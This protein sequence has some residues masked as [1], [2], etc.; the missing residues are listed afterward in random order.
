MRLAIPRV[1]LGGLLLT[2]AW[3][4]TPAPAQAKGPLIV[5]FPF[6]AR[7]VPLRPAALATLEEV[8]TT[9]VAV[10]G[11]P[12]VPRDRTLAQLKGRRGADRLCHNAVCQLAVARALG[13]QHAIVSKLRRLGRRCVLMLTLL[14]VASATT[15]RAAE[16]SGPCD[17]ESV[18]ASV[19]GALAKLCVRPKP[20]VVAPR[21]KLLPA[22]VR[23]GIDGIMDA[24][25]ACYDRYQKPGIVRVR[26][27]IATNGRV[28]RADALG[29][30]GKSPTGACVQHAVQ[31]ARFPPFLGKPMTVVYPFRL[32]SPRTLSRRE[33]L[34]AMERI[35]PLLHD[36]GRAHNHTGSAKVALSIDGSGRIT[37]L[38]IQGPLANTPV[39]GC[40]RGAVLTA[41]FRAHGGPAVNVVFPVVL[42]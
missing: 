36:C 14:D 42:R 18:L 39:G 13:A 38:T 33:L 40:V 16:S 9:R 11:L 10:H 1:V 27:R 37:R 34:A 19:R 29:A 6:D 15:K 4:A 2:L 30:L 32:V 23:A 35:R 5:V 28:A 24:V 17:E 25:R 22:D 8:M 31:A 21:L 20:A 41:R 12:V 3:C 26:L 7:G